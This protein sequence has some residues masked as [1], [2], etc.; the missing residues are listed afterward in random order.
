[1]LTNERIRALGTTA[2]TTATGIDEVV[3]S[4]ESFA[5]VQ[6]AIKNAATDVD[7]SKLNTAIRKMYSD[8]KL[9][10]EEY[11]KAMAAVEKQKADLKKATDEQSKAEKGLAGSIDEVTRAI[12]DMAKAEAEA[13]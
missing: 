8:G 6:D 5:D 13:R 11:K 10:A 1:N 4:L 2:S 9:T 7:I 3:K 12:E